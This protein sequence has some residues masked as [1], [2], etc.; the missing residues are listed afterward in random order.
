[1]TLIVNNSN[2]IFQHEVI[3]RLM[4]FDDERI[5]CSNCRRPDG[6]NTYIG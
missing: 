4:Q 1:M 3:K 5:N 2:S 6:P